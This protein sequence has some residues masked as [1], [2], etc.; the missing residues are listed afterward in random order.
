MDK[1]MMR[2]DQLGSYGDRLRQKLFN[3][4]THQAPNLKK[5]ASQ[6]SKADKIPSVSEQNLIVAVRPNQLSSQ[7]E[8]KRIDNS[9]TQ[10]VPARTMSDLFSTTMSRHAPKPK[11]LVLR[12]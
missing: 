2:S 9:A 6:I 5:A 12:Y 11:L 7:N 8:P 1:N 4:L 10:V 3:R